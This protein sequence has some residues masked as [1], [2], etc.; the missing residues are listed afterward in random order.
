MEMIEIHYNCFETIEE[1]LKEQG[2]KCKDIDIFET[3][4][5]NICY[6]WLHGILTDSEKNKCINKLH[7][8]ILKNIKNIKLNKIS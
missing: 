8:K 5:T 4:K 6:L 3:A 1:Q 7:K 2:Y